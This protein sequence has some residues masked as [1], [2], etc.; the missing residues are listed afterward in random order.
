MTKRDLTVH[1]GVYKTLSIWTE[2]I[3]ASSPCLLSLH[4]PTGSPRPELAYGKPDKVIKINTEN[5]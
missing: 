4:V 1:V 2:R 5:G 3:C